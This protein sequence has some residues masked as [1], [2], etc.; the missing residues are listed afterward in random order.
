LLKLRDFQELGHKIV[1]IIGDFTG[2]I[3]DTSDKDSE[4][5]MLSEKVIK[6]NM[7]EYAKQAGKIIDLKKCEVHYNST[8]LKKLG[9][10]EIGKQAD[11]FSVHDFISRDVIK[12]RLDE[13]KRVSLREVLYP[14]MQGYDSVAVKAD[15]EVGGTDQRFNL[16]AGRVLQEQSGK[17]PQDIIMGPLVAGTDGRKM[18]SSYGNT[19]TVTEKPSD[20]FGKVMSIQDSLIIDYFTLMTRVPMK[21]VKT[22]EEEMIKGSNPR[23][24]KMKLAHEIVR[25]YHSQHDADAAQEGFVSTF[26]KKQVPTDIHSLSPKAKDIVSVL[27]EAG[28]VTSSSEARRD[29]DGGGVRINN[30]KVQGYDTTVKKGDIVQKGKRFFVKIT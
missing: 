12:R 19:I 13:G 11:A 10:A 24:Y 18:S 9:F 21:T 3:G 15:V 16:L 5:P 22:Y 7:K 20:M 28:F 4:R 6:Q 23:D 26:A 29:I 1:F 17:A 25:F 30:E 2:V 8:W 14:L 27:K